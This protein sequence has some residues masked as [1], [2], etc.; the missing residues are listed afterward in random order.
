MRSFL[1]WAATAVGVAQHTPKAKERE[2]YNFLFARKVP[3]ALN[4]F[5][6]GCYNEAVYHMIKQIHQA[7]R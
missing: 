6:A 1:G 5:Q 2:K 3:C 7:S 4:K